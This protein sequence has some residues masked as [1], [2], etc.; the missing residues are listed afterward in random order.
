MAATTMA[1]AS[2]Y[3]GMHVLWN[4]LGETA[5]GPRADHCWILGS[6]L[7]YF[8]TFNCWRGNEV[9]KVWSLNKPVLQP[10]DA[11]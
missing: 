1:L 4:L 7:P 10:N 11:A 5:A 6:N 3:V 8:R 2:S 9:L